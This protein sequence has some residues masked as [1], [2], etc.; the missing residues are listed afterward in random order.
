M[1][2]PQTPVLAC[3]I[4]AFKVPDYSYCKTNKKTG[5]RYPLRCTDCTL[6]IKMSVLIVSNL[7]YFINKCAIISLD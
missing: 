5:H 1:R 2:Q 3:W 4:I 6:H 7:R